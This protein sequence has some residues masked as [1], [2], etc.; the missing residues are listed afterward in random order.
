MPTKSLYLSLTIIC[1]GITST[2]GQVSSAETIT[3]TPKNAQSMVEQQVLESKSV[4]ERPK[5]I[6]ILLRSAD[7]LW[8][9][10]QARAREYFTEAYKT[11]AEHFAANGFEKTDVR[12]TIGGGSVWSSLPDQRTEVIAAVSKRDPEL[13]RKFTEQMLA[14]YDKAA[15]ERDQIDKDRELGDLMRFAVGIIKTNPDVSRQMFRRVMRYPLI[16]DWFFSLNQAAGQDQ[17]FTDSIYL[18]ALRNYGTEKPHVLLYLSAYPFGKD[19][20]A[21]ISRFSGGLPPGFAPN[22]ALQQ[23]FL[24]AFFTRVGTFAANADEMSQVPGKYESPEA[25]YIAT[26]MREFEPVVLERFPDLLQRFSVA[27]SQANALLTADMQK[28]IAAR[29]QRHPPAALTFDDRIKQFEEAEI[30][31]TLTD[32]MLGP[33]IFGGRINSEEEFKRFEPWL[34]KIKDENLRADVTGQFWFLRCQL[35]IKEKRF[36]D[37]EKLAQ[38][39]P[40]LDSRALLL[41]D[42]ATKQLASINDQGLAFGTLNAVSKL[43]RSSPNS[44]AKARVLLSLAQL[45]DGI[46]HT[47]ALDEL[48]ESI[49]VINQLEDPDIFDNSVTRQIVGKDFASMTTMPLPGNSFEGVF[50]DMSKKDFDLLLAHARSLGDK[51][52]RTI[53]VISTVKNCIQPKPIAAPKKTK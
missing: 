2:N 51:Y 13:A 11:A 3:C 15:A 36:D 46:S 43:A 31:G 29:E 45:Y 40:E 21:G 44:V 37:A 28:D 17:V 49:R 47:V 19:R 8:V 5:R 33:M 6:K 41:L 23:A 7:F 26:A 48:S 9:L 24:E 34:D 14:D 10:D 53:A 18:E 1:L 25:V 22:A 39:I 20:P 30:K 35:A 4:V 16:Q 27:Q 52:F 32:S 12:K 50:T 42:I 38:K